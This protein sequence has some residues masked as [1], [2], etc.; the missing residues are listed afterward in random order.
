VET[1][2]E[3]TLVKTA[4]YPGT[5]DPITHGH[6]DVIRRARMIFDKVIVTLAE[7]PDKAP[8]FS[9]EE[10]REL[11]RLS[12]QDIPDVEVVDFGGLSVRFAESVGAVAI[13]RGLRAVSDFEYEFQMALT[14]RKL[15]AGVVTVFLMP[16]ERFTYLNS[17][18]VREVARL[19][20]DVSPF[21]PPCVEE[22]LKKKLQ[23]RA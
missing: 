17:N 21:V 8:L 5:F 22:A 16:H 4:I 18:I 13:I 7:N 6:I 3:G 20:G 14:N 11:I 2:I 23:V 1:Q 19:H 9:L 15:S 10:R 12:V